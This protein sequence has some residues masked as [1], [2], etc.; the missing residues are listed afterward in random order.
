VA[1][2]TSAVRKKIINAG[3]E[4]VV[5]N[6]DGVAVVKEEILNGGFDLIV[7]DV[8]PNGSIIRV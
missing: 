5:I 8:L 6:F 2:G 7:V 4:F 3:S 1:H